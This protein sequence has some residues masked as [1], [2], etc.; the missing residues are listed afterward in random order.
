MRGAIVLLVL[1]ASCATVQPTPPKAPSLV[2]DCGVPSTRAEMA[3]AMPVL[4]RCV[5]VEKPV[6]SCVSDMQRTEKFPAGWSL[7]ALAC[8][9]RSEGMRAWRADAEGTGTPGDAIEAVALRDWIK[10]QEANNG[11]RFRY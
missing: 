2:V 4:A 10:R 7:D 9:A 6:D 5:Q 1:L 11:L 8:A 3:E